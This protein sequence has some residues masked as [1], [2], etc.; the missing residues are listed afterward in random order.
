MMDFPTWWKDYIGGDK[1]KSLET[2]RIYAEFA[3]ES[4]QHRIAELEAA[5]I[6]LRDCDFVITPHD[7][8]DAVREIARQAL[9]PGRGE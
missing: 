5:L 6:K 4:Q 3:W 2:G 8:M 7:R 1:D 9:L